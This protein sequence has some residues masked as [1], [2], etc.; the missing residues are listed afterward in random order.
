MY[1]IHYPKMLKTN[2]AKIFIAVA[3]ISIS[4]TKAT[5]ALTDLDRNLEDIG[6]RKACGPT[7]AAPFQK[8]CPLEDKKTTPVSTSF[9]GEFFRYI[10]YFSACV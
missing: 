5:A 3:A 7:P 4:E 2:I 8:S 9:W 10:K 1:Y 6:R